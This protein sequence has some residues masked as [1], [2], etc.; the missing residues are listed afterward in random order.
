MSKKS[1]HKL[2]WRKTQASCWIARAILMRKSMELFWL[3]EA[4]TWQ[5]SPK[6]DSLVIE[7]NKKGHE[8]LL[9]SFN[10]RTCMRMNGCPWPNE[11]YEGAE[12]GEG[13]TLP[14]IHFWIHQFDVHIDAVDD[15]SHPH[16]LRVIT[17]TS[18]SRIQ[19]MGDLTVVYMHLTCDKFPLM[20]Q[21]VL[22]L[23]R[24]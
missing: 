17:Y 1:Q 12:G 6:L 5:R 18:T 2:L 13:G 16:A 8:P 7:A 23:W 15:I 3:I 11:P 10:S 22:H 24:Q 21:E 20:N 19:L 14:P 9:I 4:L